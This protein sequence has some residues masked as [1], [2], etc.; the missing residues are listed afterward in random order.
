MLYPRVTPDAGAGAQI[1]DVMVELPADIL[2]LQLVQARARSEAVELTAIDI[3]AEQAL[4]VARKY[5]RDWMNARAALVDSWRLIQFNADQLQS[6]LDVLFSGDIG[7]INPNRPFSLNSDTGRLRVGMQFDAP[8]T[9]LAERNTYRQALIEFQQAR[10]S[11]YGFEDNVATALRGTLRSALTSQ[12]QFEFQ[13]QAVL[14]AAQQIDR[15]EDIRINS[16]LSAQGSRATAA[17]DA[18]SALSDLLS[19]Q[20]SFLGFWASYE[21][22]RRGLDLDLGTM[23]LDS[24]GM[25]IDPGRIGEDYG[26]YDPWLWRTGGAECPLPQANEVLPAELLPSH[27]EHTEQLPLPGEPAVPGHENVQPHGHPAMP[28]QLEGLPRIEGLPGRPPA[29][30][31][32]ESLLPPPPVP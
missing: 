15:N 29:A 8:I 9:R 25:W 30:Q 6:Q 24:E 19:A 31:P 17:R 4:E 20:N 22:L 32:H 2:A 5:R 23:Q 3:R 26:Q 1:S 16:E 18:V 7:N 21:A 10:R 28:P 12:L 27:R 11:Y 13:R 14:I